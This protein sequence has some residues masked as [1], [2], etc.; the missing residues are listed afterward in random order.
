MS[1]TWD[2][3]TSQGSEVGCCADER[4]HS[5]GDGARPGRTVEGH[6]SRQSGEPTIGIESAVTGPY[7]RGPSSSAEL[8]DHEIRLWY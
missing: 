2:A 5:A 3:R 1:T 7:S 8:R 4:H 6:R